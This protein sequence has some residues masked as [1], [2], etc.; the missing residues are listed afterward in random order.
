MA[1]PQEATTVAAAE[2]RPGAA[3]L[4]SPSR[5]KL[6]AFGFN[7]SGGC[8]MTSAE[9][10][11]EVDW[12]E[13]VRI[14]QLAERVGF[15]AVIPV[16]RWKG[17]GGD[18][19]FN[20]RCF[21]PLAWAAGLASLTSRIQVFSTVHVPTLHP[22]RAAKETATI[23]HISGGRFGLNIVAGNNDSEIGMFESHL[24]D[25]AERYAVADEWITLV[26]RLWNEDTFDFKGEYYV[27]PGAHSEPKPRQRP[28]PVLMSAGASPTGSDFAARNADVHFTTLNDVSGI[29]GIRAHVAELK[30]NSRA[31]YGREVKV[32]TGLHVACR[33]TEQEARDYF[34]YYVH[35]KG[36][37]AG[38]HSLIKVLIPGSDGQPPTEEIGINFVAGYGAIPL[39]GTPE[40]VVDQIVELADAGLDGATMSWVDYAYGLE[41]YERDLL[42]LLQEAGIRA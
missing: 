12:P 31:R 29:E 16:A 2:S 28:G 10:T 27:A 17:Y 35:E 24:L 37:W 3:L 32:M 34:N 14:A 23:D 19:N 26:K 33:D 30:A 6:A 39:V 38:L 21:E 1:E 5:F 41:Q 20:D 9:G 40:Q 15:E 36:D 42:P 22:V 18:T 7:V 13:S 25:K 4:N 11:V 8:S